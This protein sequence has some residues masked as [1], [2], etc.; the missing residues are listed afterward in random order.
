MGR[1]PRD[2]RTRILDRREL[3]ERM[4]RPRSGRLVFS[5]G[6]FDILHRGHVALLTEARGLGDELLVAVNSDRS[7]R[8]L[9][10]PRRPWNPEWDRAFVLA[11]LEAVDHVTI[12]DEDTPL[13]LIRE[14]LP[15]VL[16]KGADY[17][18]H[19]IVGREEVLQ[20]GGEVVTIPLVEGA[21][22]SRFIE[23]IQKES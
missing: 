19:E 16:V 23:R 17:A 15:D 6:C 12:F 10:G 14:I 9:K 7:V 21:S 2:P 4:G 20:A 11:A 18:E 3:V 22:T 8:A 5:N 1:A 13:S